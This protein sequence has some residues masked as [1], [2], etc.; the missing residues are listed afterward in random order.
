[1]ET[2]I[3][4]FDEAC[5][6][7]DLYAVP[8]VGKYSYNYEFMA[9]YDIHFF[10]KVPEGASNAFPLP[11]KKSLEQMDMNSTQYFVVNAD[12]S[13][14]VHFEKYDIEKLKHFRLNMAP[15]PCIYKEKMEL[16]VGCSEMVY[17]AIYNLKD[18]EAILTCQE[19][20]K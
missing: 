7:L 11:M 2:K 15:H 17:G 5:I 3:S 19:P 9:P 8:Y 1:M 20:E 14:L 10:Q 16:D 18:S 13:D 4:K 12:I 6:L